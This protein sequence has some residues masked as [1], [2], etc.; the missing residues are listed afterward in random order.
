[1]YILPKELKRKVTEQ[2]SET[3]KI[4]KDIEFLTQSLNYYEEAQKI[5]HEMNDFPNEA[6]VHNKIGQVYQQLYDFKK[7]GQSFKESVKLFKETGDTSNEID[8]LIQLA[9]VQEFANQSKDS[10]D[11]Y[12]K[13]AIQAAKNNKTMKEEYCYG[14]LGLSFLKIESNF[15]KA[16]EW[17]EKAL[18][19]SQK[20]GSKKNEAKWLYY[21]GCCALKLGD[22]K[23]AI[24]KHSDSIVISKEIS[25]PRM[26]AL[27]YGGLGRINRAMNEQLAS[28][29]QFE[30]AII[31]FESLQE[32]EIQAEF[33]SEQADVYYASGEVE[34]AK[35]AYEKAARIIRRTDNEIGF[36]QLLGKIGLAYLYDIKDY[37]LALKYFSKASTIAKEIDTKPDFIKWLGKLAETEGKLSQYELAQDH[38]KEAIRLAGY[39]KDNEGKALLIL[40][41]GTMLYEKGDTQ[42]ASKEFKRALDFI[43]KSENEN[44]RLDILLVLANVYFDLKDN[45]EAIKHYKEARSLAMKLKNNEKLLL[46]T[47]AIALIQKD[48]NQYK[49]SLKGYQ[50]A[51]DIA[52]KLKKDIEIHSALGNIGIVYSS[53]YDLENAK[54]YL[55]DAL[56]KAREIGDN[57][58]RGKWVGSLGTVNFSEKDFVKAVENYEEAIKIFK[59]LGFRKEEGYWLYKLSQVYLTDD[60]RNDDIAIDLNEK[61][62]EI[63]QKA[64]NYEIQLDALANLGDAFLQKKEYNKAGK[65]LAKGL[66]IAVQM[67]NKCM[68]GMIQSKL[69]ETQFFVDKIGESISSY[70]KALVIAEEEKDPYAQLTNLTGLGKCYLKLNEEDKSIDYFQKATI[71]AK[72]TGDLVAEEYLSGEIAQAYI[73]TK[74]VDNAKEYLEKAFEKSQSAKSRVKWRLKIGDLLFDVGKYIEAKIE[75]DKALDS[76]KD[77]DNVDLAKLYTK[78]GKLTKNVAQTNKDFD[79]AIEY[80]K[81]GNKIANEMKMELNLSS[82]EKELGDLY[83]Q[84]KEYKKAEVCYNTALELAKK[85]RDKKTEGEAI[86]AIGNVNFEKKDFKEAMR[87]YQNSLPI[88]RDRKDNETE[89]ILSEKIKI[90][91][92]NIEN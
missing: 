77:I 8:T 56:M 16:L 46:V 86:I 64:Q 41:Y 21:S 50:E 40:G 37:S 18:K 51:L 59:K 68:E 24:D 48:E 69:G 11:S 44:Q 55:Q 79:T 7:A 32:K 9:K 74:R 4:G 76:S 60:Y 92:S 12:E 1:M 28:I 62:L 82:W 34:L 19:L 33:L 45:N 52:T 3:P 66:E 29:A 43:S 53:L 38:F 5:A 70:E 90:C 65:Y 17:F 61:V 30:S 14:Q 27:N 73:E 80:Y 13:A 2:K 6:R 89:K 42:T 72:E 91:K 58:G 85:V 84:Q 35:N 10:Q 31:I 15:K 22:L 39:Q 87:Y 81:K 75:Y 83:F 63:F 23:A 49:E 71:Y 78:L 20:I 67:K 36:Q 54:K 25:D 47:N 57:V 88:A 26:E